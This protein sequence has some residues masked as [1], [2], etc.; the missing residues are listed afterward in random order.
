[1][2]NS[3]WDAERAVRSLHTLQQPWIDTIGNGIPNEPEDGSDPQ[4][5]SPGVDRLPADTWAPYIV[6]A[7]GPVAIVSGK[8]LIQAEVRDNK[9]VKRVWAAIYP[10]SYVSPTSGDE[11]V[12]E[13]LPAL[14][15]IAHGNH[16]LSAEY[17]QFHDSGTYRVALYAED[18][19]GLKARLYVL[20]VFT[21]RSIY[22]PLIMR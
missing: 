7:R 16:Q 4:P 22:M 11:L 20:D 13:D 17:T 8:G 5:N 19:S 21:G 9:G 2:V 1:M 6:T 3:F 18:I 10:P 12:A 15:F 14:D